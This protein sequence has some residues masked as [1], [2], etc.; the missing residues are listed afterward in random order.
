VTLRIVLLAGA[1]L[2]ALGIW[3]YFRSRQ[4]GEALYYHFRCPGCNRR[5]RYRAE[6]VGHQGGC[7]HCGARVNFPPVHEA[8]E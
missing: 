4:P 1:A 2:V 5:L 7:S 6:Q 3:A 8:V